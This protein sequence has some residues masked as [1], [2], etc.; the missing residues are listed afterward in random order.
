V[1]EGVNNAT[2]EKYIMGDALVA[3]TVTEEHLANKTFAVCGEMEGN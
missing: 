2:E 3:A 1:L